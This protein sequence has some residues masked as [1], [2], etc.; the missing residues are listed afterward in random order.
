MYLLSR[1][2][3]YE[4]S[5]ITCQQKS[6]NEWAKLFIELFEEY[7]SSKLQFPKLHSWVFHICSSIHNLYQDSKKPNFIKNNKITEIYLKWNKMYLLS[8]KENYEESDITCQQESINEWAKLFI[9]L[10]EEYSSSKLQFPKLH[11]WVF[12]IC[13]SIREFGAI[14]EYTTILARKIILG[15]CINLKKS[16]YLKNPKSILETCIYIT[17]TYESLHKDYVKKPYKLTN[18]K[19]I[20]KQIMKIIRCKAII[21]ESS[22]KKI[23]KTPITLKYS[24]KLY[25]F[26]IQN[27]EIYIQTRINDP[28]L[29]KEMKFG[30]KKFL[31]CL[32]AYLDF[33]DQKL[34]EHE[35][36][37]IKFRIYSGV[38]LKYGAKM[39]ANN[40]FHKRPI[41]SNIAVKMNPDEI[42]EY[43]SDNGVCF[44]Q[45]LLITEIIMNYEESM[46]L[47]LVQWYDFKS[48]ITNF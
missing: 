7:S 28:D 36:I 29:K 30:F 35:E 39:R 5:D 4:E 6:I 48:L 42:F 34:S 25:E 14:N 22:S 9:E 8:R 41:F 32:D 12:H 1:K 43:T 24:K 20:E 2:E 33:Y 47:A 37:N 38:T 13:S 27:V 40:K 26:C 3:N 46:H 23:P 31:K 18:K 10:F 17:E 15:F 16:K 11:S 45:V 19:E 21:I 44:A